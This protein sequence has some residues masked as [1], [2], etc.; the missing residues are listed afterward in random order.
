M[1]NKLKDFF[2]FT[3]IFI[4]VNF[5]MNMYTS[6]S[7]FKNHVTLKLIEFQPIEFEF[8]I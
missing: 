3:H 4:L 6:E 2:D 8:V 1:K 5:H 7:K